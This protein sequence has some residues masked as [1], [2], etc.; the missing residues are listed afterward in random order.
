[1]IMKKIFLTLLLVIVFG[2][3]LQ[4]SAQTNQNVTVQIHQ[5]K[6]LS[7]S[8]LT[9]KF[10]SL[11]EDSRCPTGTQCIQAGNAKIQIKVS[12]AGKTAK[13][14]ELN[15]NMQPQSIFYGGYEINL[16]DVKPHPA[17][18][19]RINRNGYTATFSV[20]KQRNGR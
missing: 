1:M 10:A 9:I 3:S 7:K 6:R 13:M 8:K 18:N 5:Q 2:V 16:M 17:N 12:G 19:I 15:T 11:V 14:F 20:S 4:A